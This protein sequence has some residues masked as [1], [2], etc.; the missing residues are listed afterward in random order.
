MAMPLT[1]SLWSQVMDTQE[2]RTL[3]SLH[4]ELST[5]GIKKENLLQS[6]SWCI[7]A[8]ATSGVMLTGA[9]VITMAVSRTLVCTQS[10]RRIAQQPSPEEAAQEG[11]SAGQA[12][13]RTSG[14]ASGSVVPPA[15]PSW[16]VTL[17]PLTKTN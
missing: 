9:K 3:I 16:Q 4:E 2:I 12:G 1:Q 10:T 17:H 5:F 7:S 6:T 8:D 14:R 13:R 15:S 11:Q